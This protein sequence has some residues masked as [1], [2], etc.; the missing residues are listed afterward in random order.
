MSHRIKVGQ[1]RDQHH[2]GLTDGEED[3]L[4]SGVGDAPARPPRQVD[5]YMFVVPQ[6]EKLQGRRFSVTT[7]AGRD[8]ES[9]SGDDH[10]TI[11]SPTG[12]E[13]GTGF[14]SDGV[15][16]SDAGAAAVGCQNLSVVSD[17]PGHA[18]KS[19]QRREVAAASWSI[20]SIQSRAVCAMKTRRLL[21]SKAAW[22]NSLPTAFGM[23]MVPIYFSG[24]M[25]SRRPGGG[26]DQCLHNQ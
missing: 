6:S 14:Q 17:G 18:G 4:G 19:R 24:I 21:A 8:P 23:A 10:G 1:P 5:R 20:T 25:T 15:K 2:R 22:S 26:S 9:G 11:R 7:D 13:H 12:L 16:Q 3:P